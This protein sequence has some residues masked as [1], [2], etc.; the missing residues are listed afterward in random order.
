MNISLSQA[1]GKPPRRQGAKKDFLASSRLGGSKT[2]RLPRGSGLG[3]RAHLAFEAED[4]TGRAMFAAIRRRSR[5]PIEMLVCCIYV[6]L[7]RSL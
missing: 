3:L 5:S 4:V 6:V 1:K 7:Y 2:F